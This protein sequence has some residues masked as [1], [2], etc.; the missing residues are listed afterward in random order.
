[1]LPA[2]RIYLMYGLTEA[3]RSTYLPP[4]QVAERPD[5]IGRAIPNAEVLVLRPDGR[6]CAANEPGELVHRGPLVA[7]GYWNDP[8]KTARR[9]RPV[10][11]QAPDAPVVEREVWSGDTVRRDEDGY[12]YFIGRQDDMIK[13]SGS[14]VSPTEIE[15]EAYA[16]GLVRDAVAIGAP[17]ER[18]GQG[19]VL[20]VTP[21]QDGASDTEQLLDALKRRLPRFMLPLRIEWREDLPRTA[22]GKYDR[23]SLRSQFQRV[24]SDEGP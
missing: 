11:G 16:S 19:V 3:F 23:A 13:T 5:S 22:N 14:R 10:P 2:T 7:L 15:E 8:E 17:H 18:L 12:L 4:E 6:P 9:F 1:V 21:A 24:F 20:I